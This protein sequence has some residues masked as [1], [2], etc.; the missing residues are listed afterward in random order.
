VQVNAELTPVAEQDKAVLANLIQFYRYDLSDIRG[1]ELTAHGTFVYRFLD[2]YFVDDAREACFITAGGALAGF[3]MTCR[4]DD[5]TRE[6][7]EFFVARRHRRHGAGQAA[8]RQTFRRHP[9]PW[10]LAI[11]HANHPAA[12]FWLRVT[13]T[14]ADGPIHRIERYP[15]DVA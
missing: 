13:A 10:L 12:Q 2:H 8:A 4:L 3:T 11:D 1:Y 7:S 15:P 6:V 9:G 5:A 14:I